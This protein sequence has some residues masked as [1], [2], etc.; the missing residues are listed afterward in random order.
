MAAF[1]EDTVERVHRAWPPPESVV[2]DL[3]S[4]DEEAR[5]AALLL[6]G[7]PEQVARRPVY[8]GATPP[9]VVGSKVVKADQVELRYA[10]LGGDATEQAVVVVEVGGQSSYAAVVAPKGKGWERIATASCWCKYEEEVVDAF[11][12]LSFGTA[13]GARAFI[14]RMRRIS[15]CIRGN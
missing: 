12:S 7:V 1:G 10:A 9:V 14:G 6:M 8:N 3:R 15:G 13:A 11:V 5:H 2:R 4:G